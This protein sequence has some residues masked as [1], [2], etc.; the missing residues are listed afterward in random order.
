MSY[1]PRKTTLLTEIE[2]SLEVINEAM[3]E[4]RKSTEPGKPFEG[5]RPEELKDAQGRPLLAELVSTKAQLILAE[6]ML[7]KEG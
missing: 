1:I 6:A 4:V 5:L 3:D 2:D 7:S